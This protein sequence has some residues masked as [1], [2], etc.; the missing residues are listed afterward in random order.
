[1]SS[2]IR[3]VVVGSTLALLTACGSEEDGSC[4][5]TCDWRA[6]GSFQ[7]CTCGDCPSGYQCVNFSCEKD[8]TCTPNCTGKECGDNGCGGS[9]GTCPAAT[10]N[11][12]YGK[13]EGGG[14]LTCDDYGFNCWEWPDGCGGC[15]DCGKSGLGE[16]CCNGQTGPNGCP[17]ITR[18]GAPGMP[19]CPDDLCI[20]GVSCSG[21]TCID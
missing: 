3:L 15:V 17:G 20:C 19:C 4:S 14:C 2:V 12:V 8:G 16:D 18:C 21:G 9:C 11:C 1:M 7:G 6:C 10:P 5:S 13:C